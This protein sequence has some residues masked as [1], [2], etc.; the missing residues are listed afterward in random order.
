MTPKH[1]P[2]AAL[3]ARHTRRFGALR[4]GTGALAVGIGLMLAGC[5][6]MPTNRTLDNV[7]QPVVEHTNYTFDLTPS[8]NGGLDPVQQHRLKD[9]FG[10]LGLK[11]GDH[12]ALDDPAES[13]ATHAAV[14]AVAAQF[15]L[16]LDQVAPVTEG[17]IPA[18]SVRVVVSR[19][20]ASVPG[21]P[22]WS[23]HSDANYTNGTSRNYGC[24]VSSNLAAMVANKED[25]VHGQSG[26]GDTVVQTNTK[27]IEAYRTK[28]PTGAQALKQQATQ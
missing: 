5:G 17:A 8:P 18:G 25:L 15:G 4:L 3:S 23:A 24:A 19:A 26:S 10:A 12:I 13:G 16:I 22:D 28:G 14:E 2:V 11:Y 27:A 7:H 21:C 6:G 1:H 20:T 9:W